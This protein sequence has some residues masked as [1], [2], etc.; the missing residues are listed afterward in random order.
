M[1]NID[2]SVF[3]G[4][5]VSSP[6]TYQKFYADVEMY[7]NNFDGTD[8][9]SYMTNWVCSDIPGPDSQWQGNNV[10]RFCNKE[11]DAL[12]AKM[13]Q[14]GDINER[15][16]LA[17]A[18]NDMLVQEYMLIPLVDRGRVSAHSNTLGGI[19]LNV[20][21]SE[22][23]QATQRCSSNRIRPFSEAG[24]LLC[25]SPPTTVCWGLDSTRIGSGSFAEAIP[26][27]RINRA[28]RSFGI[29]GKEIP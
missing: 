1:R 21:D 12:V 3:F 19:V 7:A 28:I 27:S 22:L 17:K 2:A 25:C 24:S 26:D 8:P 10:P 9:E 23:W 14:T 16:K 11:Y 20:W 4:G 18:M 29:F 15:A 6:D 13:A 5:N